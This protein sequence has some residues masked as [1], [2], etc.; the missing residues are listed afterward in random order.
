MSGSA[1]RLKGIAVS[2]ATHARAA[3][4]GSVSAVRST[5]ASSKGA[6]GSTICHGTPSSSAIR[7]VRS[8]SCRSTSVS[9]AA[10][11]AVMSS[12]PLRGSGEGTT[13]S[14]DSGSSWSRN[15]R[16]CWANESGSFWSRG[17][18]V[19]GGGC[20]LVVAVSTT[21]A[22]WVMVGWSNRSARVVPVEKAARMRV[23]SWVARQRV[24][25]EVEEV[26]GDA[27]L[28]Q[29]EEVGPD[30]GEELFGDGGRC[31]V[32]AQVE[33]AVVGRGECGAV[34][35]AVGGEREGG[36]F[37]EHGRDHVVRAGWPAGGRGVPALVGCRRWLGRGRRSA[38]DRWR[39]TEAALG[40]RGAPGGRVRFRRV[41]CGSR[42]A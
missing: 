18:A 2:A 37:D 20:S 19:M 4:H 33:T 10:R 38:A 28:L 25:A 30:A 8:T 26:V 17:R 22:S 1:A 39:M 40:W 15:H 14:A 7:R 27:D 29:A 36:Q 24:P 3:V 42:G 12:S 13:Y 32:G 41:R 31:L 23:M 5:T 34:D 35:F 11:S 9:R 16:R 6:T 21:V